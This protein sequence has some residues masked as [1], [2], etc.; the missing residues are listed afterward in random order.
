V[1]DWFSDDPTAN[2][3]TS[4]VVAATLDPLAYQMAVAATPQAATV[5]VSLV[6]NEVQQLEASI[7]SAAGLSVVLYKSAGAAL[8][9][10]CGS[11]RHA[12]GTHTCFCTAQGCVPHH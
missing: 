9:E 6:L 12:V 11:R 3:S 10:L 8:R 4:D 1:A 2:C 5:V 7:V